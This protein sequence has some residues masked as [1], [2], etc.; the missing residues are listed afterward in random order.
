MS[1]K[2]RY[3]E[4]DGTYSAWH[5]RQST[6]RFIGIENAQLLAMI[7]LDASLWIKYDNN[8]KEP[9]ALIETAADVGQ[10]YKPAT[11]TQRLAM[12]ADIPAYVVL[13]KRSAAKTQPACVGQTS[14][15]S[16][17]RMLY[18][19]PES[20]W[21]Q[22]SPEEWA[23][24]LLE[25]RYWAGNGID[26]MAVPMDEESPPNECPATSEYVPDDNIPF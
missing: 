19:R 20:T 24:Q 6:R 12:K 7:D 13:Y 4:R 18:P 11:V 8:N 14:F 10:P 3:D 16:A 15:T 22:Y 17:S 5:R 26:E 23:R 21:T 2:E 9:I 1:H 25:L